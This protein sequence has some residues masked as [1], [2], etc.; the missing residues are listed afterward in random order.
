M[1]LAIGVRKGG[2]VF[3]G[4]HRLEVLSIVGLTMQ[5][6]TFPLG[7]TPSDLEVTELETIEVF[8]EVHICTAR[9]KHKDGCIRLA[10]E[11]PN[12]IRI[13]RGEVCAAG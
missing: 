12:D 11:A 1:A 8:P 7:G 10:F 9:G 5:V 6:R 3:V 13:V 2:V 4:S